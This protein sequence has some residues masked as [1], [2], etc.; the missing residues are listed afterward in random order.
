M[1]LQGYALFAFVA[2]RND[3]EPTYAGAVV[4][5]TE[6]NPVVVPLDVQHVLDVQP[7]AQP[8]DLVA[9]LVTFHTNE[10]DARRLARAE[11][12]ERGQ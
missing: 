3:A 11:R 2:A 4:G 8:V 10:G 7:G 9:N 12:K 5:W 1:W 6:G